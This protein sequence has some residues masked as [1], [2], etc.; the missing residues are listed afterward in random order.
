MSRLDAARFVG[1][2][3]ELARIEALF[4]AEP[5]AQVVALHGP[6]GVGKSALL[7]ELARRAGARGWT[8]VAIE[9][10]DLP[11][12]AGVLDAALAPA[13][14]SQRP[15]VLLDSWERLSALDSHLRNELLP[16][17]PPDAIVVLASR[18]A[19]ARGWF[20]GGWEQLVLELALGPLEDREADALLALRGVDDA[21]ARSAAIAWAG[22]SPL[23]LVLAADAGSLPSSVHAPDGPPAIVERLLRR[24]LDAEPEGEHR[25]ALAV[26]ALA[27]VTTPAL[28]AQALPGIDAD[29]AFAWLRA[30]PSAE[31]LRDGIT[32]HDLV[33]KALRADLR[34]RSPEFERELRRRIVD[35]LYA[36]S[37]TGGLLQLTLDLQHLVHDPAIRWGF[38]WDP[39]GRYRIDAPRSGD[40]RAIAERGGRAALAWL[41]S[42]HR[43]FEESPERVIIVRDHDDQV[44]GYGVGVTPASAPPYAADDPVLGPRLRHAATHVGPGGA[45]IWRQA[46]DLT[47]ERG[48]PIT[49]LIGMAGIIGAGLENPAAAYLPIVRGNDAAEAFSAACGAVAIGELAVDHGG[50]HVECHV[51]DYGPGG[52]LGFQRA[53]V[54]RELGLPPPPPPRAGPTIADVRDALKHYGSPALLADG[55][56]APG[57]GSP[58]ARAQTVRELIDRAVRDAFGPSEE[59]R[60][61]RQV[62]VRGYLD[63]APTHELAAR[64]LNL[65]RTA[66]FRRL[67][68]AVQRVSEQLGAGAQRD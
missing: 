3:A 56:L 29:A 20:T 12:L 26:A 10:R 23:A 50:V 48:S 37:T 36:T 46:V 17:L 7:R 64:E 1:R 45:V 25:G 44:A 55:P 16:R 67:R 6:A 18:R 53:A 49:G 33:G 42:A 39:S 9:A 15:L 4:T 2:S 38:S 51:L 19:P 30:H 40:L 65:S 61:L 58:S 43:Y 11:P 41:Q 59:D 47:H 5:P 62:L 14:G 54:Y 22:G 8:P 66:Y 34:R 21:D 32:V 31:P 63:P 24:L 57:H 68:T 27:R 52:L 60:R 35:A 13:L 28:L